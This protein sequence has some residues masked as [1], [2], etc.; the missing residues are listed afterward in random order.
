MATFN[1]KAAREESREKAS[2]IPPGPYLLAIRR[3]VDIRRSNSGNPY[4][5]IW[6]QVIAGAARGKTFR[7]ILSLNTGSDGAK[8]RLSILFEQVGWEDS[9][10]LEDQ[11]QLEEALLDRGFKAV[12][13][14]EFK[15]GYW[16]ND[17][18][19]YVTGDQI[20]DADHQAIEEWE[21]APDEFVEPERKNRTSGRDDRDAP[22]PGDE[23]AP[24]Y[25]Y[26]GGSRSGG[27]DDD[28]PF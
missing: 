3:I 15:D 26:G 4:A 25:G 1:P 22:P 23:D 20:S 18:E 12:V 7:C 24:G 19:R 6:V 28:I 16:N 17:I 9:I 10:D 13:K 5:I 2:G 11:K 8:F 21:R 14:R 27:P